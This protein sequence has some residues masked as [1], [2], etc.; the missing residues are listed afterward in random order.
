M[1]FYIKILFI[2]DAISS[3]VSFYAVHTFCNY[4][5]FILERWLQNRRYPSM[6]RYSLAEYLMTLSL[7]SPQPPAPLAVSSDAWATPRS[8]VRW[9]TSL[10]PRRQSGHS[11][12]SAHCSGPH[13]SSSSVREVSDQSVNLVM[14]VESLFVVSLVA[15]LMYKKER[16]VF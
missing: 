5:I 3:F 4:I 16:R 8:M 13:P 10:R 14:L 6:V 2:V 11:C 15:Q 1:L 12:R 7:W 9:S